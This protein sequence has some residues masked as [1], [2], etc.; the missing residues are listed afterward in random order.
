ML[1]PFLKWA[2]GKRWLVDSEDFHL[3]V[4]F[5]T[6]IEPFLGGGAVFFAL[7]PKRSLL[8]DLNG[9]LTETYSVVK[10]APEAL[11]AELA[12]HAARHS[13]KYYYYVRGLILESSIK[14][15]GQFLYLNRTCF[16]GIYRENLKGQF[17]VPRGTKNAVLMAGD[18]FAAWSACLENA[19][20]SVADFSNTI[21]RAGPGDLI[22]ADPPYTARHNKNGFVKYN[23]TI[24]SWEDQKRLAVALRGASERGA[25]FVLTNAN[26]EAIR[27]LYASIGGMRVIVRSSVIAASADNRGETT[28]LIVTSL[29]NPGAKGTFS[30]MDTP[31]I[32]SSSD[33]NPPEN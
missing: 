6:Y 16:N 9:R 24:F 21:D 25:N 10:D 22:F 7:C 26:H 27:E 4:K 11:E 18:D 2:G 14:R 15:A 31:R 20:I 19:E 23:Q 29:S 30:L 33:G 8:S 32:L 28:E 3:P 17:N 5:N 12:R 1:M 13:D